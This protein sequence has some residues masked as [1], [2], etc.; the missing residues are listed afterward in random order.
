VLV[1]TKWREKYLSLASQ[2]QRHFDSFFEHI[3]DVTFLLKHY[4]SPHTLLQ[5]AHDAPFKDSSPRPR[6][7][8]YYLNLLI[9]HQCYADTLSKPKSKLCL[10]SVDL[11]LQPNLRELPLMYDYRKLGH[12]Q[13]RNERLSWYIIPLIVP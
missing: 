11:R 2:S 1:C 3:E 4:S 12:T 7:A 5:I 13:E 9:L 6:T 10:R 8:R